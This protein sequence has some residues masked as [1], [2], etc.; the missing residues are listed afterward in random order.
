MV[1]ASE[2]QRR[3]VMGMLSKFNN[4]ISGIRA[5]SETPLML[6]I[7]VGD[8][9]EEL[10]VAHNK[11]IADLKKEE[12]KIKRDVDRA[13]VV[14]SEKDR[15]SVPLLD[16]TYVIRGGQPKERQTVKRLLDVVGNEP[17]LRDI[18]TI[19]I[20]DNLKVPFEFHLEARSISIRNS[21]LHVKGSDIPI[22]LAIGVLTQG[23]LLKNP[24]VGEQ[25]AF[26]KAKETVSI[27]LLEREHKEKRL[28]EV[29]SAEVYNVGGEQPK[30]DVLEYTGPSIA[31]LEAKITSVAQ[32][33][34][35]P[36]YGVPSN[37]DLKR[38]MEEQERSSMY[39]IGGADESK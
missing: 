2:K 25:Q 5:K 37:D 16:T 15:G 19:R 21:E 24:G 12:E 17:V 1:F 13:Q 31:P 26:D 23:M 39:Y 6:K 22:D 32:E 33:G 28:K 27:Y 35:V 20:D 11:M 10:E 30:Y 4:E 18:N 14:F 29:Q 8:S 7:G 3:H 38:K 36:E 9:D 34:S